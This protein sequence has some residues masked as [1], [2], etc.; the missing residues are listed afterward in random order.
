VLEGPIM[1]LAK[2]GPHY[3]PRKRGEENESNEE[4]TKKRAFSQKRGKDL[5]RGIAS[6][7]KGREDQLMKRATKQYL[8]RR[9]KRGGEVG[10]PVA[11]QKGFLMILEEGI[12]N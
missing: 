7:K 2:E 3:A 1:R 5:Q 11:G 4:S 12:R 8:A 6:G 9:R 10:Q